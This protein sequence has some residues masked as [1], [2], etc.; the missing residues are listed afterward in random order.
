MED[1]RDRVVLVV[2]GYPEEMEMF[3]STN[4][5]LRSRFPTIIDFPDYTT[6]QLMAIVDSI[7]AKQRYLLD[8]DAADQ[9]ALRARRRAPHQGVR[10][11]SGRT[12]PVR[13]SHQPARVTGHE[14]DRPL[15]C[16]PDHADRRRRPRPG[17]L[18]KR[19]AALVAA[20]AMVA[21]AW[22]V[23]SAIVDDGGDAGDGAQSGQ[24]L[25]LTC[26]TEL[27]AVC[28]QLV[29][30]ADRLEV[31]VEDPGRTA[32]RIAQQPDGTDPGF[33]AWLADGPWAAMVVDDH[34]FSGVEG[35]V[36]GEPTEVLGRSPA[37][38]VVQAAQEDGLTRAC[39]GTVTWRCIGD[40]AGTYRVGL[41]APDRGDGLVPLSAATASYFGTTSYSSV[42]FE[43]PG[44]SVWFDTLTRLSS[45]AP[46]TWAPVRPWRQ[47]SARPARSTS[48]ERSRRSPGPCSTIARTG[49]PSTLSPCRPPRCSWSHEPGRTPHAARASR[50]CDGA[51]H[52]G[53]PGLAATERSD[54]VGRGDPRYVGAPLGRRAQRA[55]GPVVS[56]VRRRSIKV[57]AAVSLTVLAVFATACSTGDEGA[58]GSGTTWTRA[59]RT[60]SR[61]T[62]GQLQKSTC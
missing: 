2:A 26:A 47:R 8:D 3:L 56:E 42:D 44:F 24:P 58:D 35:E 16:G 27:A 20:V 15:R 10:Q 41:T 43:E 28:G 39:D 21:G 13:G 52:A 6:D 22:A 12:Q 1:R 19:L 45:G 59:E 9:A 32:D 25:R 54:G 36:I 62:P 30:E 51:Q 46:S 37:V 29:A 55:E 53:G 38:I 34:A 50:C 48:S 49:T 18:V 14:A 31:T 57:V 23:R 60:A 4:P 40:Q 7:G 61:S 33:D 17:R 11:R 5:G